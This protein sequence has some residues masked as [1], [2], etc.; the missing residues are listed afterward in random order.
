MDVR[1]WA[2]VAAVLHVAA[3]AIAAIVLAPGT[4]GDEASR[5]TYIASHSQAWMAGWLAWA[6]AT[7][8]LLG[9][10]LALSRRLGATPLLQLGLAAIAAAAGIEFAGHLHN[11]FEVVK[12]AAGANADP[13]SLAE[14]GRLA[15][16]RGSR[17]SFASRL[18]QARWL[19]A[20]IPQPLFAIGTLIFVRAIAHAGGS[21]V[22][23]V[24]GGASAATSLAMAAAALF[25][26][27]WPFSAATAVAV[28]TLV[29]FL[30]G[31]ARE[32][33]RWP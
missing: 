7:T 24:A 28:T 25:A 2:I 9:L 13:T 10:F 23:V 4:T 18:E 3:L 20:A 5:A 12:A 31:L 17:A 21:R 19:G 30:A 26:P 27:E 33:R 8:G 15:I 32:S 22:V 29:V 1:T 11:A 16:G 6:I 14:L